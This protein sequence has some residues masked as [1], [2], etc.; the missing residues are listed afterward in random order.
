[1]VKKVWQTDRQNQSYSCLVA[2]KNIIIQYIM[3]IGMNV[4]TEDA[5]IRCSFVPW[6][7]LTTDSGLLLVSHQ[8]PKLAWNLLI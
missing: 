6:G 1:M 4:T 5:L 8:S 3:F 7:E 2:A